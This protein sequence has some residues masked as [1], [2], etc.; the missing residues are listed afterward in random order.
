LNVSRLRTLKAKEDG[1]QNL[2]N[3][4]HLQ[5]RDLSNDKESY[6][7]LLHTLI[8]QGL[9]RLLEPKVSIVVRKKDKPLV[10][11][12]LHAVADEYKKKTE[13]NVELDV[14]LVHF[15]PSPEDAVNQDEA[16][17]GGVI[18][19][20]H[21]GRIMCSNT[22]DARLAMAYEHRLPEIRT[23]LFG[24]SQSRVHFD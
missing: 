4:S 22:L 7:K 23:T 14:D 20:S 15:L 9:L 6:K 18:L 8:L 16:C 12:V 19:S 11:Q 10:D 3:Q 5:L 21:E 17:S 24:K 2:Y 13:K 1:I